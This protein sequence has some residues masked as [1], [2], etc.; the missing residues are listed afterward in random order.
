MRIE[1]YSCISD[2]L[3]T[4]IPSFTL[5]NQTTGKNILGANP[6]LA[7]REVC[8]SDVLDFEQTILLVN[9]LCHLRAVLD[10]VKHV[11][12]LGEM[13]LAVCLIISILT[14]SLKEQKWIIL[15]CGCVRRMLENKGIVSSRALS[16][17]SKRCKR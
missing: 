6:S 5:L 13:L 12:S 4:T 11:F 10:H 2:T 14:I 16:V 9:S 8:G 3:L 7:F 17:Q 1:L 15:T